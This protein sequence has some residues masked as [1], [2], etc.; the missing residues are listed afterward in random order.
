M[1]NVKFAYGT[2]TPSTSTTGFDDGCIYFH[3]S[4]KKIYMRQGSTIT[5]FDGN[6]TDTI[7]KTGS[8]NTSSKIYLVGATSQSSTGVTTYSHDTAYIGTDG[9]LYTNSQR[10]GTGWVTL[11]GATGVSYNSFMSN[12]TYTTANTIYVKLDAIPHNLL[13]PRMC[14]FELKD[15]NSA[16]SSGTY[17]FVLEKLVNGMSGYKSDY[18]GWSS[19]GTGSVN[20]HMFHSLY[21]DSSHG[22]S[23]WFDWFILW[24]NRTD[25]RISSY[26][27]FWETDNR[28]VGTPTDGNYY[29]DHDAYYDGDASPYIK[30]MAVKY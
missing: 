16:S 18:L 17:Y 25:K 10:A 28:Y 29:T 7:T 1:A 2:S 23:L 5:T 12:T 21:K 22:Y 3:T 24:G 13:F 15:S 9:F 30:I 8:G 4:A 6:N 14:K 20:A 27:G 26:Y 11:N 19:F